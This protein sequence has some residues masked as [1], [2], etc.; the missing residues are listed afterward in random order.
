MKG[1]NEHYCHDGNTHDLDVLYRVLSVE[2]QCF[3]VNALMKTREEGRE[4]GM[5]H[6]VR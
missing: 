6:G 2:S 3:S 1:I 5:A 4:G